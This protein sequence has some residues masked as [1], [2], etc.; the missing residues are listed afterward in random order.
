MAGCGG[1]LALPR[2]GTVT[3]GGGHVAGAWDCT[4]ATMSIATSDG[5]I[6][7]A[8]PWQSGNRDASDAPG[9]RGTDAPVPSDGV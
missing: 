8:M 1:A 6:H 2:L 7:T 9:S 3:G 4:W 5:A